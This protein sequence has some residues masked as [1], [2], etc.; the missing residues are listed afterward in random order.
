[1][2]FRERRQRTV[3][4]PPVDPESLSPASGS[5]RPARPA[6]G[7][8]TYGSKQSVS[9]ITCSSDCLI[10]LGTLIPTRSSLVVVQRTAAGRTDQHLDLVVGHAWNQRL[11]LVQI[12]R[13]PPER[14]WPS[15]SGAAGSC[16]DSASRNNCGLHGKIPVVAGICPL[17]TRV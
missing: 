11:D 9:Q 10:S 2:Q 16:A 1:M 4:I 12:P 15:C 6:R 7:G 5:R 17:T 8:A 14:N 13:V 3:H